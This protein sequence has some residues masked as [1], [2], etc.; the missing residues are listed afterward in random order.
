MLTVIVVTLPEKAVHGDVH[1]AF[2]FAPQHLNRTCV[3]EPDC[4]KTHGHQYIFED[5]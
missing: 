4:S 5:R 1:N 2:S 3:N